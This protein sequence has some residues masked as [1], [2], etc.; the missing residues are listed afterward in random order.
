MS[1]ASAKPP[2]GPG[3]GPPDKS[4]AEPSPPPR[5]RRKTAAALRYDAASDDAPRIL[6]T[7]TGSAAD[8]IVQL[9]QEHGVPVHADPQLAELLSAL[10]AGDFIPEELYSIVA[11]ILIFVYEVDDD[12]AELRHKLTPPPD[13]S[14][15][16]EIP[17]R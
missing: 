17:A 13:D 10:D 16:R 7:G 4:A 12:F 14:L 8:E 15:P 9:A 3:S 11:E 1:G 2:P 6:A 5:R